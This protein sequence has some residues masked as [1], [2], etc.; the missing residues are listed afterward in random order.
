MASHPIPPATPELDE[1]PLSYEE[2]W[3][4]ARSMRGILKESYAKLGGAEEYHRK[5]RESWGKES[6]KLT[7][8][9]IGQIC[10]PES[11]KL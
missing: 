4:L 5:E 7:V 2:G 9:G 11:V 3:A 8:P 6:D 10:P 1:T